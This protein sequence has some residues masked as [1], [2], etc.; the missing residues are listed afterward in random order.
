M[1]AIAVTFLCVILMYPTA[2]TVAVQRTI[3]AFG[4]AGPR[5]GEDAPEARARTWIA[6]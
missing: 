2:Y 6:W 5:E 1:V 4:L 3:H